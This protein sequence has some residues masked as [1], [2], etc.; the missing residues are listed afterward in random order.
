MAAGL[1]CRTFWASKKYE[2]KEDAPEQ[3]NDLACARHE[4]S[5]LS[6]IGTLQK[7]VPSILAIKTNLF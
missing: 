3:T 5:V 1:F 6:T 7:L 4:A 2:R